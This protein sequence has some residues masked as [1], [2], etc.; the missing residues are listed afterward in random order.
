MAKSEW[1]DKLE[2]DLAVETISNGTLYIPSGELSDPAE[3]AKKLTAEKERLE[4]ELDRSKKMLSNQN[5]IS[6]AP[7]AKVQSEKDKMEAYRKQYEA[8]VE[9]LDVL[10]KH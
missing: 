5:F 2:G 10:N 7:E 6:K 8:I 3:E 9:R 1:M 4:K